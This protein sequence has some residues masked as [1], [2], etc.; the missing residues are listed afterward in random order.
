MS[1]PVQTFTVA[2]RNDERYNELAYARKVAAT[3]GTDHH[4]VLIGPEDLSDFIPRLIYHQDEPIADWVCVPLHFVAELARQNGTIVVQVGEGSDEL[5]HGYDHYAANARFHR[6]LWQP[7]QRVPPWG[8][9]AAAAGVRGLARRAGRGRHYARMFTDAAESRLPFWGGAVCYRD[10]AKD[11]ILAGAWSNGWD[12]YEIVEQ[13]WREAE[14]ADPG[15][16]LLQRMTYIELKRRLAELLLMRVDKMTMASSVEA[17]VPFLDHELVE[18][19]VA[20]PP[21]AKVRDG[22]GKYLLKRAVRG[23]VADEI[24]DRPKQGFG[25]PVSEW[26]RG[27]LGVRARAEIRR[28]ALAERRLL[29]YEALERMW[30]EHRAGQVEWGFHLWVIYNISAWYDYWIANRDPAPLVRGVPA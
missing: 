19:G 10:D 9:Q 12:S 13:T 16:D 15:S 3:Y 23:I 30:A 4:E 7:M 26:F 24:V 1:S 25:A 11:A 14:R 8:R 2:F 22:V 20:L 21:R 6:T 18:F 29:D 17:R 27:D 5:F 28:S